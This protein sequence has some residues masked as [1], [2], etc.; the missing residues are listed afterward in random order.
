MIIRIVRMH[1]KKGE[2]AKFLALFDAHKDK[3]RAFAGCSHL[4]LLKDIRDPQCF[5]TLSHWD[6]AHSLENYRQSTLFE[7]VWRQVKPLF[8]KQTE[9]FSLEKFIEC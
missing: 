9:A 8:S 3:I 5:T 4:E 2:E 7:T 6:Q 1:F